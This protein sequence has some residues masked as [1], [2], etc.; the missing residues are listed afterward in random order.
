VAP[1]WSYVLLLHA[2]QSREK[3]LKMNE[4]LQ[5]FFASNPEVSKKEVAN[6][7][8]KITKTINEL[9]ESFIQDYSQNASKIDELKIYTAAS[10]YLES[11]LGVEIT[12]HSPDEALKYDPK[13][14][15]KFALPFKPAL[16]FE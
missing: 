8:P 3:G 4:I 15:A 7:L 14:K 10:K 11:E 1:K 2:V 12:I 6:A 5:S 13:D 9:G 16:Y